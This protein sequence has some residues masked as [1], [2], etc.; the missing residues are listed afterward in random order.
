MDEADIIISSI[1]RQRVDLF[2]FSV[3]FQVWHDGCS[4]QAY[5]RL[6]KIDSLLWDEEFFRT[7]TVLHIALADKILYLKQN[8]YTTFFPYP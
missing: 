2:E 8:L 4:L 3:N 1:R 7:G 6:Q 5:P